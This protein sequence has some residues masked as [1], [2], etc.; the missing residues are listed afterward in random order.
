MLLFTKEE[1]I[2]ME[3]R[4]FVDDWMRKGET[5]KMKMRVFERIMV[6]DV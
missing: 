2:T 6:W 1:P 5:L 3:E 4:E